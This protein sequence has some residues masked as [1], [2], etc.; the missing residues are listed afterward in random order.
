MN[1][2]QLALPAAMCLAIVGAQLAAQDTDP[3]AKSGAALGVQNIKTLVYSGFGSS[4]VVGQNPTTAAAWPRVS[5]SA[6]KAEIDYDLGAMRVETRREQGQI[7]PRG[8]GPVFAGERRE[9]Q[10]VNG[11][12][13]W[14]VPFGAPPQGRGRRGGAGATPPAEAGASAQP[15]PPSSAD[16]AAA[17][18]PPPGGRGRGAVAVALAPEAT[19]A[20][21]PFR[22]QQ[23]WTTPHG[24]LKA[25]AANH[26]S[27]RRVPEGT[28]VSFVLDGKTR[29]TGVING[30][31]EVQRVSTW[32]ANPVL[33]DMLVETAYHDYA[34]FA[35]GVLF[36]MHITQRQGGHPALD[37]YITTVE[38]N[39][40]VDAA[41]PDSLQGAKPAAPVVD[42]QK[43]A[44][45]VYYLRGGSHHSVAIEMS[46]HVVLVEAPLDDERSLAIVNNITGGTIP[47]KPIRFVVNTHHH[48]DHA[49]GLRA[50]VDAGA[51][52]VTHQSN[53]AFYEAAWAAPRTLAP[54][55]LSVSKRV[56]NFQ[57]FTDKRVMTSGNRTVEVYQIANSPHAEGFAMVYLPSEKLL[58]EADAY[59]PPASATPEAPPPPPAFPGFGPAITPSAR[60]LYDNI[61][62]LKLDVAQI[63]P[64]H[65]QGLVKMSEF[66]TA[67]GR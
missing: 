14:N 22:A 34:K 45:G 17:S 39:A 57:T 41:I 6:Y 30:R 62:R 2:R 65:G 44:E 54:D 8:G 37:L 7:Q 47:N 59:T 16:P 9:I 64:L 61:V 27:T 36:P 11:A 58:I 23:I 3:V 10:A 19:F 63:V 50:L 52:V 28:E 31:S 51:T 1:L 33:G 60:N 43:I 13:A 21:A 38:P 5:L 67:V 42:V 35:N 53:Q 55:R 66:A 4:Y 29:F 32:V 15:A 18:P 26:A 24:F 12:I 48:F 49:G 56:A 20:D 46:D 40:Q 25:A